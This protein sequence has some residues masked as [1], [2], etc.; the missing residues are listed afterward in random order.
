MWTI[1]MHH[2]NLLPDAFAAPASC[3]TKP[4][5]PYVFLDLRGVRERGRGRPFEIVG[6]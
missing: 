6:Q 4:T 5:W 2:Q 3:S 1:G